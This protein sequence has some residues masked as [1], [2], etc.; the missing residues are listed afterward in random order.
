M[1]SETLRYPAGDVEWR[2]ASTSKKASAWMALTGRRP[3]E[4]F[5]RRLLQ[6]PSEKTPLSRSS[7]LRANLKPGRLPA[8]ASSPTSSP[9][10]P[11][12]KNFSRPLTNSDR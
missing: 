9:S 2:S 7:S 4:I 1:R 8:P 11:I 12:P 6:P 10:W 3:A 5:F